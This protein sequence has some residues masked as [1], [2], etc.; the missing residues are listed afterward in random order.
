MY[1]YLNANEKN[2]FIINVH[3]FF[4]NSLFKENETKF[5]TFF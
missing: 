2:V 4:A 3:N 1:E 5:D